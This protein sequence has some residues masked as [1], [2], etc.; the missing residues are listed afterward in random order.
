MNENG[1]T[2]IMTEAD[3]IAGAERELQAVSVNLQSLYYRKRAEE[4]GMQL[5][6][7]RLAAITRQIAQ[8][9]ERRAAIV[10]A[11]EL[12]RKLTAK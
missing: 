12:H 7:V 11:L 5:H 9:E 1:L 4:R 10:E 6:V 8:D 2:D 3:V